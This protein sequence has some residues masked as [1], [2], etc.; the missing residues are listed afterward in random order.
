[1]FFFME[2]LPRS[3]KSYETVSEYILPAL[4]KGRPVDAYV[5]GLNHQQFA[6]LAEIS[7]EKC[8]ELLVTIKREDVPRIYEVARKDALVVIDELQ[9]FWQ[10]GRQP[11]NDEMTKFITEHGHEGQDIIGMGQC[12]ND[13]HT[14]WR[15]RTAR[16]FTFQKQ[17]AIGRPNN[18]KWTAY[19]GQMTEKG[20]KFSKINSGVRE[21]NAKY[22]GL[23]KSHSDGVSNFDTFKDDR[24]NLFKNKTFLF[25]IPL[26]FVVFFYA[27]YYIYGFFT[28]G[29]FNDS[30]EAVKP[31]VQKQTDFDRLQAQFNSQP[32]AKI[33]TAPKPQVSLPKAPERNLAPTNYLKDISERY[34]LRLEAYVVKKDGTKIVRVQAF[35]DSYHL[36]EYFTE[37]EIESLGWSVDIK[38]Y[39]LNLTS[40]VDD[41]VIIV[42]PWPI[43]PYGKVSEQS[44]SSL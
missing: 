3:G 1:M 34:R 40:S 29:A 15:N 6:D 24:T 16:K 25:Y 27:L 36:Q 11:L 32:P 20:I 41:T 21:Y 39:G 42:R 37:T 38:D 31:V 4:Q 12:L 18:Y 9:N 14:M 8:Q 10:K 13:C 23:Y 30:P 2:G 44:S 5:E 43:D 19:Q 35:D 33:E 28:E 26:F 22:F 17:D 7:L